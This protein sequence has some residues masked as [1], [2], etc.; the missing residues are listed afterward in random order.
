M[1]LPAVYVTLMAFAIALVAL[2]EL[3]A[4]NVWLLVIGSKEVNVIEEGQ[5]WAFI[6]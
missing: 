5:F 6:L 3:L 2:I 4:L 1:E